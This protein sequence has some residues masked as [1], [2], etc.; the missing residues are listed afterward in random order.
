MLIKSCDQILATME[1]MLSVFQMDLGKISSE[2]QTL[3]DKSFSMNIKL[4][5]RTVSYLFL[6]CVMMHRSSAI[7]Y[8]NNLLLI[9]FKIYNKVKKT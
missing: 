9:Y 1:N 7:A 6:W 5:N 8:K 2:I 3:Q 4:K